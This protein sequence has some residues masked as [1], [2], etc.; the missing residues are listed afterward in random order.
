MRSRGGNVLASEKN[1]AFCGRHKACDGLQRGGF[2]GTICANQSYQFTRL[3]SKAYS[4][5]RLNA[6]VA[7]LQ[8]SQLKGGLRPMVSHA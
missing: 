3:D 7:D 5:D 6:A 2:A 1:L 8:V 4:F